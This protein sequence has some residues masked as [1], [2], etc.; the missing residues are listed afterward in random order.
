MDPPQSSVNINCI[1]FISSPVADYETDEMSSETLLEQC[2]L[3][4]DIHLIM[5]VKSAMHLLHK[6]YNENHEISL[7]DYKREMENQFDI[8]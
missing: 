1:L 7:L 3:H 8:L 2:I 6:L 4:K 5:E